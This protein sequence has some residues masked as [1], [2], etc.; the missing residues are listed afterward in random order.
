MIASIGVGNS[1]LSV[2]DKLWK[3]GKYGIPVGTCYSVGIAGYTLGGGFGLNSR[4]F[5]LAVDR[6]TGIEIVTADGMLRKVCENR[7]KDLFWALRGAGGGNFGI[8]T[9]FYFHL[10]DV[11]QKYVWVIKYYSCN[12]FQ[13]IFYKW[14]NWMLTNIPDSITSFLSTKDNPCAIKLSIMN[15][16]VNLIESEIQMELIRNIFPNITESDIMYGSHL[17]ALKPISSDYWT[18]NVTSQFYHKSKGFFVSKILTKD[19]IGVIAK[20]LE[21]RPFIG[22]AFEMHG[23]AINRVM[24]RKMSYVHRTSLYVAQFK[25]FLYVR[26]NTLEETITRGK[27]YEDELNSLITELQF[28]SNG[29]HYQNYVDN[30]LANWFSEYY[31]ENG[32]RLKRIKRI[33]DSENFFFF[34]QSIPVL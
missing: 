5:G 18:L 14:Q 6:L 11:S 15:Y 3:L 26:N 20:S 24:R 19:E 7:D 2:S 25:F 34:N 22:F 1:M 8:V 16:N 32:K 23:G 9:K 29:E 4:K 33:F 17:D 12:Q 28:M 21:K 30:D 10:F 31:K 13:E 27:L